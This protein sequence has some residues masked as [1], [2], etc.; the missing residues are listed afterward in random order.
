M[1]LNHINLNLLRSLQVLLEECHVS[2]AA[3]R[4]NITQ[5]A[6]SRQLAQLRELCSDP[7]LVRQGNSL[8]PT[9]KAV[10][11]QEQLTYLLE[12][13]EQLLRDK[14]FDPKTWQQE[15][16]FSSSDYVAQYIVPDVVSEMVKQAPNVDLAYRLW[17]PNYMQS[18]AET[19]IHL[20]STMQPNKPENIMSIKIGEDKSVCLMRSGHPASNKKSITVNDLAYYPHV[21]VTGG[22]DK[23][24]IADEALRTMGVNRR[25]ALQ[26]PFFSAAVNALLSSDYLMIVPKHIATN[27]AQDHPLMFYSLPFDPDPHRY[28]LMWHPKYD[29]DKAHS[30]I[31]DL[32]LGCI[33]TSKHSIAMI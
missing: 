32:I 15:F 2:R 6:M 9:L 18:F 29:Q 5:S 4:L 25:I 16:V 12:E 3:F 26:I 31:R 23:D 20:A 27:L 10:G 11:M 33:R 1:S 21:K 7:L 17:K 8:V 30:W 22:G 28:W 19:G 13:F 14:P 24:S